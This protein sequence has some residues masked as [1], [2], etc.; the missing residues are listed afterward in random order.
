MTMDPRPATTADLPVI[1]E[2]VTAAYARYLGRMGRP[3][4]PMP[5][6]YAAV[7]AGQLW[8]TGQPVTGLIELTEAATPCTSGTWPSTPGPGHRSRPVRV[9]SP[10]HRRGAA[11]APSRRP[12]RAA[13]LAALELGDGDLSPAGRAEVLA[14][15][16]GTLRAPQLR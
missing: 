9:A 1:R 15:A 10:S 12:G 6:D 11:P 7:D 5:A 2:V 4:A 3:P 8:V 13:T 16:L 14:L